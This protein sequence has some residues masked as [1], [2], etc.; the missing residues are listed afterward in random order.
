MPSSLALL[1]VAIG[2]AIGA[3]LR[4]TLVAFLTNSTGSPTASLPFGTLVVNVLGSLV[5]G[6]AIVIFQ[7]KLPDH[8]IL[9]MALVG[10]VLGS[11]TTFSAFSLETLNL[12][13]QGSSIAAMLNIFSNITLCLLATAAGLWLGKTILN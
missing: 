12:F 6:I 10:G 1:Y 9:R 11:F 5:I 7:N 8:N 13:N 2:G 4:V 3:V